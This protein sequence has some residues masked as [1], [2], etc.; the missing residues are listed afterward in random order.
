[1]K[2]LS[3]FILAVFS[4]QFSS[5]QL[6]TWSNPSTF[7]VDD[8]TKNFTITLDATK[9]NAALKNYGATSDVYVHI[10]V[11]TSASTSSS[12]WRYV[13]YNQNFTQT[14]PGLNA[15]YAGTNKWSFAFGS[16]NT[17]RAFFGVPA[18]E[19]IY[20][21]ALLFRSGN[22]SIVHRNTD[23]SDMYIPIYTSALAATITDPFKQ[24]TYVPKSEPISKVVGNTIAITG[25]SNISATLQL[26]FNGTLIQ[27]ASSATTITAATS[28]TIT[29]SGTQVIILKATAGA[30]TVSDTVTFYV[31]GTVT[32]ANP[33]AGIRDGI[34][35][36]PGDTSVTFLL[37]APYKTRVCIIGDM[38]GSNWLETATYQM[39]K[40]VDGNY[41]W[42]RV[43]G[44]TPGQEY[45]FQY[46]VDGSLAVTDPYVE[47]ILD[48]WNDPYIDASTY[49]SLKAYPTGYTT[50]VVGIF[51]TRAPSYTWTASSYTRPDKRNLIVY[52]LLLRDFVAKHD[53]KTMVDTL[54]YLKTLGVN[55]IQFMP[56][57]EFEG[58]N[59]WGYNPDFYFAVDKYYGPA[60]DF[61]RFVDLCHANGIAVIMDIA[62]NHSFGLSP[63]VQLY[64]DAV[65]SRPA[66]NS[67]WFNTTATHPYSVGYDFNHE[68]LQTR[69]FTSRVLEH[70][71]VNYKIDGFRFDL[72]KGF[73]QTSNPS[74]VG[75]WSAYDQ[76]RINI[77]NRYYDTMQLKSPGSIAILEHFADN[78][79][80]KVLS[81]KG[82]ML[83]GNMNYNYGQISMGWN[84]GRDISS[85][86]A[87]NRGWSNPYLVSYMESHDEER[88][89][90]QNINN[91]NGYSYNGVYSVKDTNQA[92]RRIELAQA[93]LLTIP[94][95]K[96]I[97]Q[98]GELAYDSSINFCQNGTISTNCRTD[99][100]PIRWGYFKDNERK[101]L[102]DVIANINKLRADPLYKDLF[103]LNNVSA[104]DYFNYYIG[105]YYFKSMIMK[106][107]AAQMVVVGNFDVAYASGNVTFPSAGTWYDYLS[108]ATFNA[109]GASQS[110]NLA[111]GEY[112]IYLNLRISLV[113]AYI[114]NFSGV[115]IEGNNRLNW[116]VT[117]EQNL[118]HYELERSAD[119]KD[120]ISLG[121]IMVTGSGKYNYIDNATTHAVHYYRLKLVNQD[122]SYKYSA[123]VRLS[124]SGMQAA[125]VKANP[126]PFADQLTVQIESIRS[127][128]VVLSILDISGRQLVRKKQ[129]LNT[130]M[131]TFD[132]I[133]AGKLTPGIYMLRVTVNGQLQ[134]IK[135]V[136]SK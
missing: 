68:S 80:E 128:E 55:A 132:I 15:A 121:N 9:G 45:S 27:S 62:L 20:K 46:M 30:S 23:G 5:G 125:F 101:H 72:A 28:P 40:S 81:D 94:G 126:N 127:E 95:P 97:W 34:N 108:G 57:N 19:T 88:I 129:M 4:L 134:S 67:P 58:N 17:I 105:D 70:W 6:L 71:L 100:K 44:L 78:S 54:N 90:Y 21:I 107:G 130:G 103:T 26:Y 115:H 117:N 66:S 53:W 39:K 83:W 8:S 124:S 33:P 110:F 38:P 93:F 77:W 14:N 43:T 118:T 133:E 60:N 84:T 75:C 109:T 113:P 10:G 3:V 106:R 7:P 24:P 91:G 11:I 36:E 37:Y 120:F 131:N 99:M 56:I 96:M 116:N 92:P 49:P 59:S 136:K 74:C 98:F 111:P 102:Y 73:T 31:A 42:L 1:M 13:K 47:K 135:I 65:N 18:G 82:F 61:K 29:T 85:A 52:E 69:Y 89:N 12:N 16:T 122:G 2:K 32:T 63:L 119:G 41:W 112:H 123:V 48:P 25:K 22:G 87:S 76:S 104:G 35:Y 79:E 86:V 50:G 64:W 114:T 51:Q